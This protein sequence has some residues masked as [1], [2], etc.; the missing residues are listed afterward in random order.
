MDNNNK[1]YFDR[2][3]IVDAFIWLIKQKIFSFKSIV[4]ILS[5]TGIIICFALNI[6][7]GILY[8]I[9]ISVFSSMILIWGI[10]EVNAK[11]EKIEE[12]KKHTI[13]YNRLIPLLKEYYE[14]YLNLYIFTCRDKVKKG[15]KVLVNLYSCK[16]TFLR[17]IKE[18]NPFYKPGYYSDINKLK[19][20]FNRIKNNNGKK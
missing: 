9:C 19:D 6:Q 1:L 13:L 17:Q 16:D 15:D 5:F 8:D 2:K 18:S 11:K 20:I 4:S 10:D 12:E 3:V 7:S 14:S